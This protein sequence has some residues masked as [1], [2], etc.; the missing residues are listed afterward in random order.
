MLGRREE[1]RTVVKGVL[2]DLF[3]TLITESET[4][5]L[6][7]GSLASRLGLEREAFREQWAC[8]RRAVTIGQVSFAGAIAEIGVALGSPVDPALLEALCRERVAA[9]A[10][11]LDK[12]DTAVL[13]VLDELRLQGKRIGIVSNC[14]AEDVATYRDSRLAPR[15]QCALFSFAIGMAKPD[16]AIYQEAARRIGVAPAAT[17]FIGD[18]ADDEL[19]GATHAGVRAFK[20]LW[21]L[22]RWPHAQWEESSTT[23]RSV[24]DVTRL[25]A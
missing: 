24:E 14:F 1:T 19:T 22:A 7:V 18:G 3:E 25:V 10:V 13:D 6:G 4:R 16:P 15:V 17:V 8:R 12:I 5:P 9:K 21:Y 20:A 2:F 11:P 23:L